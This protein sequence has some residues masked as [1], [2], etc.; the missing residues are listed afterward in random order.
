MLYGCVTRTRNYLYDIGWKKAYSVG[1]PVV[2]VGNLS[3]GGTGK[4]PVSEYLIAECLKRGLRTA[5]LSRGYGRKTKGYLRV[6]SKGGSTEDFGDESRQVAA[7]FPQAIVAVCED[8]VTGGKRLVQEEKVQIIILDDAFQHRRIH[9]DLNLLVVDAQIPPS[10][11]WL[12]PAG[13]LREHRAGIRRADAIIVNKVESQHQIQK[14]QAEFGS[15]PTAYCKP[16][17]FGLKPFFPNH[18]PDRSLAG[19]KIIAFSGIGRNAQFAETIQQ[20]GATLVKFHGF[21][22]HHPFTQAE[23][24]KILTEFASYQENS[25]NFTPGFV[26]TT[27]K[28]FHRLA[29]M[30]WL[31]TL[32]SQPLYFLPIGLKWLKGENHILHLLT[33]TLNNYDGSNQ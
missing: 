26:V 10:K 19:A 2:A 20:A 6:P 11:D 4:T 25:G 31:Q 23:L 3:A 15:L 13:R 28:D 14:L 22:D 29:G 24:A 18:Q 32:E 1:V 8:R 7:K 21:P 17:P 27:E 9:R 16:T 30:P 5:Y 33:E 12:I